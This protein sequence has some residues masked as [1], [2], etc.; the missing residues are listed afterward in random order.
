MKKTAEIGKVIDQFVSLLEDQ[1]Y[2]SPSKV[3]RLI[4]ASKDIRKSFAELEITENVNHIYEALCEKG[5]K[6]IEEI[7]QNKQDPKG[8][9][10][11]AQLYTRYLKAANGDFKGTST[12]AI[13]VYFRYYMACAILFLA[14]S[15]QY[16]GFVLPAVMFVP[17]FL[18]V[19]GIK[20]RSYTGWLMSMAVIPVA[21]MTSIIWIQFGFSVLGNSGAIAAKLMETN[22]LSAA[23]AMGLTVVPPILGVI[24]FPCAIMMAYTGYKSRDYYI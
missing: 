15:P 19:K 18:G 3:A 16:F 7:K 14:L 11:R 21:L 12:K 20:N 17:I 10:N 9:L 22:G 24:L 8:N 13:G 23:V 1:T 6:V 2:F 4:L 5:N